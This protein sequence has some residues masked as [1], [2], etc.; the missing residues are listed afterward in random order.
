MELLSGGTFLLLVPF[1][2][3]SIAAPMPV[4]RNYEYISKGVISQMDKK[5]PGT[6][7]GLI[8]DGLVSLGGFGLGLGFGFHLGRINHGQWRDIKRGGR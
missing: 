2:N 5:S 6:R 8:G 4:H 7:P 1:A 3:K